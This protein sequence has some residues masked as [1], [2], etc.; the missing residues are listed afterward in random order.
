M[1]TNILTEGLASLPIGATEGFLAYL[2]RFALHFMVLLVIVRGLYYQK[3]KRRDYLFTFLLIGAMIFL[4]CSILDSVQL[5]LGMALGLFAI[6][7]IIRYRTSQMPIKEMTYLF[8]VIGLAVINA[9]ASAQIGLPELIF[10]NLIIMLITY[11]L[12]RLWTVQHVSRKVIQYDRIDLIK[13]EKSADLQ[14]DLE[15]RLG[16]EILR[17]DIGKVDFLRDSAKLVVYYN[18]HTENNMADDIEQYYPS[19]ND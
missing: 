6:F 12:E 17:V 8:I 11:A 16:L 14:S 15:E 2:I 10:T 9:L 19:N 1:T 4:L 3:S 18:A 13:P 5:E 7:G